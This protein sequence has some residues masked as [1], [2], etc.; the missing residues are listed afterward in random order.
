MPV[1]KEARR[2]T[3]YDY[4]RWD[5]GERWEL[6]DGVPYSMS[7]TPLRKHQG[8]LIELVG[9][10][11]NFLKDKPCKVYTAPF[12]VRLGGLGDE[13]DTVVQPDI[14][15]VCDK[16]KLDDRGCNGAPDMLIE[17][18]SPSTAAKDKVTKFNKYQSASVREYWI[19]DPDSKTV[20]SHVLENGRY[21]TYAYS[22]EDA[23]PVQI[24]EG[25]KIDLQEVFAE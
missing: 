4:Y 16:T 5:D 21:I 3:Y 7:P 8:I 1:P 11:H 20:A 17:I 24:L 6:I 18:L 19:V 9:Q 12:D 10:I 25:C 13:D 15:V 23:A 2:Y 22:N 14:V